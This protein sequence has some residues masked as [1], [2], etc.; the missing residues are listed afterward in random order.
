MNKEN[1]IDKPIVRTLVLF[2]ILLSVGLI[3]R[4]PAWAFPSVY[5]LHGVLASPFFAAL[6]FWHFRR[7]G[8]L[9]QFEVAVLLLAAFLGVM[10]LIMGLSFLVLAVITGLIYA[11]LVKIPKMRRNT[12][13]AVCFGALDYPITLVVGIISGS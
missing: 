5:A 3:T 7:N 11:A 9:V 13:T 10:S 2:V 4:A 8:T 12:I 1:L 6:A